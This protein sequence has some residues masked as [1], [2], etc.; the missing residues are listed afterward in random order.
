MIQPRLPVIPLKI[1]CVTSPSVIPA[2]A[3]IQSPDSV[4]LC[5]FR[6]WWCRWQPTWA[7]AMKIGTDKP[8]VGATLVVAR[9]RR[10]PIFIPLCG[11]HKA[12]VI[13]SEARN[14]KSMITR[15][16]S[17]CHVYV[18][19]NSG[20]QRENSP[21]RLYLRTDT[22][23]SSTPLRYAQNDSD[24]VAFSSLES[25]SIVKCLPLSA[26]R[27]RDTERGGV[28][29]HSSQQDQPNLTI[30]QQNATKCPRMPQIHGFSRYRNVAAPPILQRLEPS[31]ARLDAQERMVYHGSVS[32]I[33]L[34]MPT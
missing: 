18:M 5:H 10:Q 2:E 3:G 9:S 14:L 1:A 8:V 31:A 17:Q 23:D 29:S 24:G 33:S 19:T 20:K 4:G 13:P 25:G 30:T 7:I 21:G 15:P 6:A 26:R 16:D 22:L 11:L 32:S 27:G 34:P 12:M 28:L